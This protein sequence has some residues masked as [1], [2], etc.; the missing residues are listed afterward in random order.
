MLIGLL[1]L[2]LLIP[3]AASL[4][5]KR[6]AIRPLLAA[7]MREFGASVAEVGA[8]DAWRRAEVA[9]CVVGGDRRHVNGV[10]SK[11]HDRAA[12]WSGEAMLGSSSMELLD[13]GGGGHGEAKAAGAADADSPALLNETW[14]AT[15]D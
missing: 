13:A 7:L 8:Q 5:D 1:R 4:K 10:L 9:V 3:S 14:D 12:A 6:A 2:E 15:S 11:A